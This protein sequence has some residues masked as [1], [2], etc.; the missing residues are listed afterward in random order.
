MLSVQVIAVLF[1]WGIVAAFERGTVVVSEQATV[2]VSQQAIG[3]AFGGTVVVVVTSEHFAAEAF[4]QAV[5]VVFEQYAGVVVRGGVEQPSGE[6][7]GVASVQGVGSI[8][9]IWEWL[10]EQLS[11]ETEL[12]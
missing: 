2:E 4:E 6:L 8:G 10:V 7:P 3:V 9:G 1:D 12:A 11:E 5:E